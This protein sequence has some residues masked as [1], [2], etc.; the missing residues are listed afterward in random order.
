MKFK[1]ML[2]LGL[3][4]AVPAVLYA[5][6]GGAQI[7]P[8]SIGASPECPSSDA[9]GLNNKPYPNELQVTAFGWNCSGFGHHALL[10]SAATGTID[11]APPSPATGGHARAVS[12]GGTVVGV[13]QG[14][15][16]FAAFVRPPGGP[17]ELLPILPDMIYSFAESIDA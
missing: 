5:A 4:I 8:V 2:Q 11:L 14:G 16:V 3:L 6:P 12:D 7:L 10:W 15:G 9:T 1:A 17:A 13:A